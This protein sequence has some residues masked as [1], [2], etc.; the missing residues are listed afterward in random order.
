MKTLVKPRRGVV[1]EATLY[2]MFLLAVV[3]AIAVGT[4]LVV[5]RA[6]GVDYRNTRV[7][8]AAEAGADAVMAQL[9]ADM[10]TGPISAAQLAALTPPSLAGFTFDNVSAVSTG[11]LAPRQITDG[12]YAGLYALITNYDI[13][14]EVHDPLGNRGGAI[15]SVKA[16]AIPI[17]QFGIFY[18]KDLEINNGPPMNFAGWIHSNG[19]IYLSSTDSYFHDAITTPNNVYHNR[20]DTNDPENGSTIDNDAGTPNPIT[21]DSRSLPVPAAFRAASHAAFSDRLKTNAYGVDSLK[22]PLPTG[23]PPVTVI[24]P[25]NAGDDQQLQRAKF[26]W[27]ADWYIELPSATLLAGQQ[28]TGGAI[29][30]GASTRSGGKGL[31]SVADCA[32]IFSHSRYWDGREGRMVDALDIDA[33]NLNAWSLANPANA[34][35]ILYVTVPGW[36]NQSVLATTYHA[37]RVVNGAT[38]NAPLTIATNLPLYVKGNFNLNLNWRSASLI[39][40][41]II[42]QSNAWNDLAHQAQGVTSAAS[43]EINAAILAGSW[44]T[45]CDWFVC[46]TNP[47]GGGVENF[48][49]FLE[50]WGGKTLT[51]RGSLVSMHYSLQTFGPWTGAYGG[52]YSPPN[53]Q[54]QFDTR[55]SD[56]SNLPPGTPVVGS[57]VQTAFRPAY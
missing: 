36:Q 47:Y 14:S 18:E 4:V 40:D 7:N 37:I 55:F 6:S 49:R 11:T 23:V 5:Q 17:F 22:V 2:V 26:S 52:Y 13:T 3:I 1:L 50:D 15:V 41:A 21:F 10:A 27:K 9:E 54:W 8:Y 19:N 30:G 44:P 24:L 45:A 16:Q 56:P 34:P 29:P 39:G 33:G 32:T 42:I 12:A 28:C 35:A 51:Y 25:R 48:P 43:T 38:L 20:K 57:L 46:G 53:R 31:P